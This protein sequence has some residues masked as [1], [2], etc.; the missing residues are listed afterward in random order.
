MSETTLGWIVLI[1]SCL[2]WLFMWI[3]E[4][5][6]RIRIDNRAWRDARVRMGLPLKYRRNVRRIS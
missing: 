6:E 5:L 3:V 2:A 1:V 4:L